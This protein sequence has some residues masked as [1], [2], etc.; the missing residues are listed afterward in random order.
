[1]SPLEAFDTSPEAARVQREA[2][3]RL[4]GAERLRIA[5]ELS[6]MTR[7]LALAGLKR[8]RGASKREDLIA[9]LIE[10]CYGPAALP[11][12]TR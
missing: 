3:A 1:M 6:Q 8:M 7:D 10:L 11:D 4:T 5:L 12:A 2:V 9:A